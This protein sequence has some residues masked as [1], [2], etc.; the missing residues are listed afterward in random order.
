MTSVQRFLDPSHI[1][2]AQHCRTRLKIPIMRSQISCTAAFPGHRSHHLSITL[3]FLL[4]IP[5]IGQKRNTERFEKNMKWFCAQ[6]EHT[7][8]FK[9]KM[10]ILQFQCFLDVVPD[11]CYPIFLSSPTTAC[12]SWTFLVFLFVFSSFYFPNS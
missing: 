5:Q 9:I 8:F 11:S 6:L 1:A 7:Q 10:T 2:T 12:F 4:K 3:T